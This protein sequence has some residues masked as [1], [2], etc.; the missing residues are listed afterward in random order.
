MSAPELRVVSVA[1]EMDS[2]ACGIRLLKYCPVSLP[3]NFNSAFNH[4]NSLGSL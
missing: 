3:A 2:T 4:T 1:K